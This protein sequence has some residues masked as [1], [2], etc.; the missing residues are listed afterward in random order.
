MRKEYAVVT[1]M[2]AKREAN[3]AKNAYIIYDRSELQPNY[4]Y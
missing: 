3:T 2:T 1:K 4:E